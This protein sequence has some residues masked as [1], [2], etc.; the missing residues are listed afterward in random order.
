VALMAEQ[1]ESLPDLDGYKPPQNVY[2]EESQVRTLIW[3]SFLKSDE[4]DETKG[5]D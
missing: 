4:G 1:R 5:Y 2:A 3:Q